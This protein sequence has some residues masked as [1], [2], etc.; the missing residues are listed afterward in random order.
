MLVVLSEFV[1]LFDTAKWIGACNQVKRNMDQ[2]FKEEK[3]AT[4]KLNAAAAAESTARYNKIMEKMKIIEQN[5]KAA[6]K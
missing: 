5:E 4:R 1:W 6:G 2:C 3:E